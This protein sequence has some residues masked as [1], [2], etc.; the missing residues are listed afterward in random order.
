M[1]VLAWFSWVEHDFATVLVCW[2]WHGFGVFAFEIKYS[3]VVLWN[4]RGRRLELFFLFGPGFL[5]TLWVLRKGLSRIVDFGVD[6]YIKL[7]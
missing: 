1:F 6:C 4:F 3:F 2:F 5:F 7:Y